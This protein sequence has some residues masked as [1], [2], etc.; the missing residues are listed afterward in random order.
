MLRHLL[1]LQQRSLPG[2]AGLQLPGHQQVDSGLGL[3]NVC[4]DALATFKSLLCC[5]KLLQRQL[6]L[7]RQQC[8]A[9][10]RKQH[11]QIRFNH[12]YAQQL[13][14]S[15]QHSLGFRPLCAGNVHTQAQLR[16][17]QRLT[18]LQV[19]SVAEVLLFGRGGLTHEIG[20]GPRQVIFEPVGVEGYVWIELGLGLIQS[21]D[22][23]H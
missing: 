11:L 13:H 18:Q 3:V 22:H 16:P 9:F 6:P 8:F 7:N 20:L 10:L 2:L 5:V 14:L 21:L 12:A 17:V 19:L 23:T 15:R 4:A 1:Q